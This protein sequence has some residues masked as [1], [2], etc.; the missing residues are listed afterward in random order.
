M[1]KHL[2]FS[3]LLVWSSGCLSR[4]TSWLN[5][6]SV[7]PSSTI[8]T[9]EEFSVADLNKDNVID[10]NE[11]ATFSQSQDSVDFTTP[12]IVICAII[13][14]IAACCYFSSA[15]FFFK[16]KLQKIKDFAS[17]KYRQTKELIFKK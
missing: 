10:R 4:G 12:L 9:P 13:A 8:P 16:N 3:S 1:I 14:L 6:E 11:S 17:K 2:L 7:P 5:K 15:G